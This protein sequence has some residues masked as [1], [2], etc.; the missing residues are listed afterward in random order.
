[1]KHRHV[2]LVDVSMLDTCR[3]RTRRDTSRTRVWHV[4]IHVPKKK[5]KKMWT[6]SGIRLR[7][8]NP[9]RGHCTGH[10]NEESLWFLEFFF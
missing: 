10:A 4:I 7:L 3:T 6:R 8:A 9:D 1:M 5:L 2:F